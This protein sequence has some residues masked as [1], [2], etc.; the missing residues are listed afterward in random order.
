MRQL[1]VT[2]DE[3]GA[4]AES[5]FQLKL[6]RYFNGALYVPE[7]SRTL[8]L[9]ETC[10]ELAIQKL[11]PPEKWR[12]RDWAGRPIEWEDNVKHEQNITMTQNGWEAY[13]SCGWTSD[14]VFLSNVHA[15]EAAQEH[16]AEEHPREPTDVEIYGAGSS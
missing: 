15:S 16:G 6:R 9:C 10:A 2:C 14:E 5:G 1:K 4:P 12:E 13:C 3:C 7:N 8:D 11:G